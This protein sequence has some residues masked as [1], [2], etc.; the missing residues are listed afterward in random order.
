M[1]IA[2]VGTGISGLVAAYLLADEHELTV[3]E[4]GSYVGGHTNTL[5]V[6]IGEQQYSVDTGFIVY[7][8][9]NYPNFT[10]LL[11][12]LGVDTQPSN[13]SFSVRCEDTGLEYSG[14]SINSLFAQRRNILRPGFWRM[15]LGIR[16]FYREAA[17]LLD[18]E[19]TT[20]TLG[21]YLRQKSYP[22]EFLDWHLGPMGSAVWS[23]GREKIQDFPARRFVE[24]FEN[25][26]F[27][28][29]SNRP[30]WRV[31]QGGSRLYVQAMT[32]KFR[33]RIRLNCPVNSIKRTGNTVE[34]ITEVS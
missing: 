25:H 31:I 22:R 30:Q 2:I 18:S 24:F 23:T 28:R 26:G 21:E 13:M 29:L 33:D 16:R 17:E 20:I 1:R 14:T 3:F 27:L 34:V 15:I 9:R 4:S 7:N 5:D 32:K 10:H 11:N 8:E 6:S 12:N 19:T